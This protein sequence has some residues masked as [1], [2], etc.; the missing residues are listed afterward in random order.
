MRHRHLLVVS[1]VT[2]MLSAGYR[3]GQAMVARNVG[4]GVISGVVLAAGVVMACLVVGVS[5]RLPSDLVSELRQREAFEAR[6]QT[7]PRLGEV[8]V[9]RYHWVTEEELRQALARQRF[10][11]RRVG[12]ILV[13]MGAISSKQLMQALI[14]QRN[15]TGAAPRMTAKAEENWTGKRERV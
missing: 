3:L 6:V 7:A 11:G 14:E 4:Q 8:L 13:A 5:R 10:S 9:H 15:E 1:V 12:E 2:L